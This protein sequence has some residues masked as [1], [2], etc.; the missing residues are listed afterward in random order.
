M[1]TYLVSGVSDINRKILQGL[2]RITEIFRIVAWKE[3]GTYNINP[4]QLGLLLLIER[5][6]SITIRELQRITSLDKTTLS[7]SIKSLEIKKLVKKH[8]NSTDRRNKPIILTP[9]GKKLFTKLQERINIFENFLRSYNNQE[10]IYKFI[11]EFI[12]F[13]LDSQIIQEQRMCFLCRFF[14][15]EEEK[16]YCNFLNSPLAI[17]NLQIDCKDFQRP[18]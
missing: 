13:A 5:Q 1:I 10:V 6:S 14:K 12:K 3:S 17:Q 7:K 15:K 4:T 9:A 18:I 11:L 16:F 2:E 8:V